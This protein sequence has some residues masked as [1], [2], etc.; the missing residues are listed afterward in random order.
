MKIVKSN[1]LVGYTAALALVLA[2]AA[3]T[4]SHASDE[5]ILPGAICQPTSVGISATR[6]FYSG[7]SVVNFVREQPGQFSVAR[8][9]CPLVRD[10]VTKRWVKILVRVRDNSNLDYVSCTASNPS[11]FGTSGY[12]TT[13][14]SGSTASFRG[15]TSLTFYRPRGD[16]DRGAFHVNCS[17]PGNVSNGSFS[18]IHSIRWEEE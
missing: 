18:A 14:R 9:H 3:P 12:N 17:L 1:P 13:K 16:Y 7:G 2:V 5:K 4:T 15:Y 8:L 10:R 6:M 11:A